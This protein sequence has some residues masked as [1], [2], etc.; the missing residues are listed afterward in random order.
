MYSVSQHF[1]YTPT[2]VAAELVQAPMLRDEQIVAADEEP[3]SPCLDMV[4]E[5]A[6]A[7]RPRTAIKRAR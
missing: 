3:Q 1:I 2:L 6:S 4:L 5:N 7:V